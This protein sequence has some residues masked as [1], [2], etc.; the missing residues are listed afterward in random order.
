MESLRDK[1]D[2]MNSV[3]IWSSKIKIYDSRVQS[4]AGK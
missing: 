4:T 2:K 1:Y 3:L